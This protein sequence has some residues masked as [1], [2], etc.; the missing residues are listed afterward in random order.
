[1][2]KSRPDFL[3]ILRTLSN[4]DAKFIIVG[5]YLA[6]C[7]IPRAPDESKWQEFG[8]TRKSAALLTH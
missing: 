6:G 7:A 2:E 1:M 3:L 5:G 8:R 4:H